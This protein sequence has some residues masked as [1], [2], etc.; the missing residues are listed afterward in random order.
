MSQRL[1]LA[2][3]LLG[4]PPTLLLDEPMNGL[5]A[6]GMAWIR[7]LLRTLAGEGRTVFV[8]SH[9][10]SEMA[11]LADQVVVIGRGRLIANTTVA[12]FVARAGDA[13]IR[14]RTTEPDRLARLLADRST[15]VRRA[16]DGTL[17][18]SGVGAGEVGELAARHGVP[19]HE[20]TEEQTPLEAAFLELT[21]D[22]VEYRARAR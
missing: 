2:A 18:V 1:G 19:L 3:A 4:D 22:E 14:V 21:R 7:Q 12:Q 11:Q 16:D 8:S 10:M 15:S 17:S 6:E 20:L 9:V 13:R 5:D